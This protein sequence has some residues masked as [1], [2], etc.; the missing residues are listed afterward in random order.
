MID[1]ISSTL[2]P[3]YLHIK[4]V[5]LLFV[6]MWFWSTSVAYTYYL[7]PLFRAWQQNPQEIDRIHLRNWAMERFDDGAILEHIAFPIVLLTGVLLTLIS[8]WSPDAGWFALKLV[9]VV[10]VFLP[11]EIV[12]YHLAHFGG[13]K[14]KLRES[15]AIEDYEDVLRVHWKFLVLSTPIVA[16]SIT[17]VVFL[18]ITKPF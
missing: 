1:T 3:Y 14:Q 8:G 16:V 5:H 9:L 12:D 13:N 17:L 10:L 18:A 2:A 4:F 15:G 7:V 11:I 6:A